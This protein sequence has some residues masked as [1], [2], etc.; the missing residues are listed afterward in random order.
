MPQISAL[1]GGEPAEAALTGDH[2]GDLRATLDLVDV[3]S[4]HFAW[5][6]NVGSFA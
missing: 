5:S 6:A 2:E 1:R 4:L 3:V